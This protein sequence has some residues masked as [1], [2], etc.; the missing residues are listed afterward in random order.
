MQKRGVTFCSEG[1][2][3][4]TVSWLKSLPCV[5][6]PAAESETLACRFVCLQSV[7]E[8]GQWLFSPSNSGVKSYPHPNHQ[9]FYSRFQRSQNFA[10]KNKIW[11]QQGIPAIRVSQGLHANQMPVGFVFSCAYAFSSS[12]PDIAEVENLKLCFWSEASRDL[13]QQEEKYVSKMQD[14]STLSTT[15]VT[16]SQCNNPIWLLVSGHTH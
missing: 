4:A 9:K 10:L 2:N 3:K 16:K 14:L 1:C 6:L 5:T 8:V 12:V 11:Q 15:L 7:A 13:K